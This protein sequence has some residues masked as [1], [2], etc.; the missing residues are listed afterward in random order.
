MQVPGLWAAA[1]GRG[2]RLDYRNVEGRAPASGDRHQVF[3][4]DAHRQLAGSLRR[5]QAAAGRVQSRIGDGIRQDVHLR[6]VGEAA[7][8]RFSRNDTWNST[9][10]F[11]GLTGVEYAIMRLNAAKNVRDFK[12][13]V[14]RCG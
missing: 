13:L 6:A 8:T 11:R 4:P 14:R 2:E 1:D 9:R 3:G 12:P 7:D 5:R 10:N